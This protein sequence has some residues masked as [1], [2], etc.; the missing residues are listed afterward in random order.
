MLTVSRHNTGRL[1]C[2]RQ[3]LQAGGNIWTCS[4]VGGNQ[5]WRYI[6]IFSILPSDTLHVSFHLKVIK[7]SHVYS[8]SQKLKYTI[9]HFRD[10][11]LKKRMD[12][13]SNVLSYNK[14]QSFTMEK[15]VQ[16]VLFKIC[17]LSLFSFHPL[18]LTNLGCQS[19]KSIS[20]YIS[21]LKSVGPFI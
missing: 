1:Q 16:T 3:K 6:S 13:K 14:Y 9:K 11:Y 8:H 19:W 5:N 10:A 4:Q 20:R 12:P 7:F 21:L 2:S 18:M 17:Q 15:T